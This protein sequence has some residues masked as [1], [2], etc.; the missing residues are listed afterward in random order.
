M[1]DEL[2]SRRAVLL[3]ASNIV[4]SLP[5]V[6]DA[7]R[8]AWGSPLD[9]LAA[10]GHGRS[11]GME[12]RVLGRTLPGI[13]QCGL[14]EALQSRPQA[15]TA[16][17]VTDIGNDILYGASA[18][19]IARWVEKCLGR[20]DPITDQ[21][22]VARLPTASLERL[23]TSRFLLMRTIFFPK[24]RL[25][26]QGALDTSMELNERLAEL[27][28]NRG[29]ETCEPVKEWYGL[30]P[31]HVRHRY[32]PAAWQQFFAGWC[33]DEL[34]DEADHS[35]VRWLQL[36]GLRPQQRRWFGVQQRRA[37]PSKRLNDGSL[38]SFY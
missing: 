37:Q 24:S 32:K 18:N 22:V 4:R 25:T 12:S 34:P 5:I 14:W 3:G 19:Q 20:L 15:P 11:Y 7:A 27:A 9:I 31:I 28:A 1:L 17:L 33:G 10:T 26:L 2:P 35:F 13:L 21:I 36:R 29:I 23:G 38:L 30:D 16:A 6:V 8:N